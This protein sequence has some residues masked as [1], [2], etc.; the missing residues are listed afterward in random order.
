[1]RVTLFESN[2]PAQER[3]EILLYLL[4]DPNEES[5]SLLV[6]YLNYDAE[7]SPINAIFNYRGEFISGIKALVINKVARQ[8]QPEIKTLLFHLLGRY[9]L[10]SEIRSALLNAL[11]NEFQIRDQA[12]S[13]IFTQATQENIPLNIYTNLLEEYSKILSEQSRLSYL[14]A[15][16]LSPDF[17]SSDFPTKFN[18]DILQLIISIK[19]E[20]EGLF[21]LLQTMADKCTRP[22]KNYYQKDYLACYHEAVGYVSVL[23]RFDHW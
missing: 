7:V 16:I 21:L 9:Y 8:H 17:V 13:I 4:N 1:M 22:N 20:K 10:F 3:E 5:T 19:G 23:K 11:T 18:R 6:E 14:T 15:I 12:L 2:A